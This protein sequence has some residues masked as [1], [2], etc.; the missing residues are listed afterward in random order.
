MPK[1]LVVTSVLVFLLGAGDIP[2]RCMRIL[3]SQNRILGF[4][5]LFQISSITKI[6]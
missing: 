4:L 1:T 5:K 3:S 2:Q 6:K